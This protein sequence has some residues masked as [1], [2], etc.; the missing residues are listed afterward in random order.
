MLIE[1]IS[2]LS[3][4]QIRVRLCLPTNIQSARLPPRLQRPRQRG[5][6]GHVS[7]EEAKD[8]DWE[9]RRPGKL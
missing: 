9:Q 6:G 7:L 5:L 1:G 3:R 2:S 4:F 8:A